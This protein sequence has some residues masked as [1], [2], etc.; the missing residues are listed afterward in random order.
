MLDPSRRRELAAFAPFIAKWGDR[1]TPPAGEEDATLASYPYLARSFAFT[2]REPGT[3]PA[4]ANL[5]NFTFGATPSMGLSGASI[6]G[7]KY[8]VRRLVDAISRDFF[9]EDAEAHYLSLLRYD[10]QE[11]TTAS[12]PDEGIGEPLR[13]LATA[14]E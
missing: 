5:H 9:M 14:A 12:W 2:E 3:A 4:L 13:G 1:F 11:L 10:E 8:G 7:L 6:S